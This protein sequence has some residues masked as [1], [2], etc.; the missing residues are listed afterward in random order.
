MCHF[1]AQNGS[2]VLNELFL[3]KTINITFIYQ[4]ALFIVQI[5]SDP[6]LWGCTIFGP[7]MVHLPPKKTF[8]KKFLTLF[9]TAYW[10]LSL[11]KILKKFLKQ[12]QSYEDVPF[13]DPKWPICPNEIFFF[14][15]FRKL[16]NKSCSFHSCLS[17]CEK[18]DINLLIKYW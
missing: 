17:T 4:L 10:A 5:R 16:V 1:R 9:S 3:I 12:I 11:S 8:E 18:S 2:F 15:F 14:F 13:M 6:E 7:K